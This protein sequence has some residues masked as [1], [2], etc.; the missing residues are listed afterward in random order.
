[1]VLDEHDETLQDERSPTWHARDVAI[2][3]S[4]RANVPCWLVSPSP[5]LEALSWAGGRVQRPSRIEERSGWPFVEVVDRSAEESPTASPVT[6]TMLDLCRDPQQR[7]LCVLNTKGRARRLMCRSCH[8]LATCAAC[9]AGVSQN[10]EGLLACV[11]CD[12]ARPAVCRACGSTRLAAVGVGVARLRDELEAAVRRPVVE[13]S[14]DVSDD[15]VSSAPRNAVF[16]G[17]EA[18]LH[19]V[20]AATA[21]VFVDI[22][23]ELLAPRFRAAEDAMS[24]IVRAAR[25]V[26]SRGGG[27]RVVLQTN[28]PRHEVIQAALHADPSRLEQPERERRSLLG[29]PPF[30]ALAA[31]TGT[32]ASAWLHPTPLGLDVVGPAQGRWLVRAESWEALADALASLGARPRGVRVE[33]DPHRV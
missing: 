31:V 28:Q 8:A 17:T 11:R 25:L 32:Q 9:G 33:V 2:E 14:S 24:L 27:G 16:L 26:G 22:D 7:V 13:V 29:L 10:R 20:G 21:V 3:R 15:V 1:M 6:R 4:R 19:R 30:R 18:V 12:A 23:D 5:S